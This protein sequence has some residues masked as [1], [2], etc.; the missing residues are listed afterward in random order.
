MENNIHVII[1]KQCL[2]SN[3]VIQLS[4]ACITIY[5]HQKKKQHVTA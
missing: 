1:V 2:G 5:K 3:P 4:V